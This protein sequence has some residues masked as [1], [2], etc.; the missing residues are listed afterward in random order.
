VPAHLP[1]AA[2]DRVIEAT[3]RKAQSH[4]AVLEVVPT[5][6]RRCRDAQLV[7]I[8]DLAVDIDRRAAF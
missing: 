2:L 5:L 4:N 3:E 1:V 7:R 8:L 6:A